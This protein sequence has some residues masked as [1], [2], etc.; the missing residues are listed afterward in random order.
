M[1]HPLREHGN[2]VLSGRRQGIVKDAW[3][4]D[5]RERNRGWSSGCRVLVGVLQVVQALRQYDRS[6]VDLRIDLRVAGE[7]WQPVDHEIDLDCAA[8]GMPPANVGNEVIRPG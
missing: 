8:T 7:D 6:A 3:D 2:D 4:A 5:V 1:G